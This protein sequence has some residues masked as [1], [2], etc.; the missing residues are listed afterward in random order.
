MK[1]TKDIYLSFVLK[2]KKKT[3]KQKGYLY[4]ENF[5]VLAR[6]NLYQ[7]AVYIYVFFF[8]YMTVYIW[9]IN[10]EGK[11]INLLVCMESIFRIGLEEEERKS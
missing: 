1:S 2:N 4:S 5:W 10:D 11:L 8:F 9:L 7:R 6:W 3:N